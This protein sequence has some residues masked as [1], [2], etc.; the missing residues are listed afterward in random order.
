MASKFP[1]VS[2]LSQFIRDR[3]IYQLENIPGQKDLVLDGELMKPLDR[4]VGASVL[5]AHGVAKIFKFDFTQKAL[6]GCNQR[7]YI[8][9]PR[10]EMM[11]HIARQINCERSLE[12]K[13]TYRILMTPRKVSIY[14]EGVYGYVTVEEFILDLIPLD[15]DVL[16]LELSDFLPRFY[17]HNDYTWLNTVA[18]SLVHFQSVYRQIP[19]VCGIGRAAKKIHE[20]MLAMTEYH[21]KTEDENFEIGK[22]FIIDRDVDFVT[23]LSSQLTYEGILDETFGIQSGYIEFTKEITGKDKPTR[24]LLSSQDEIYDQIRN[25]HFSTVFEFLSWKVKEVQSGY[26][27]RHSLTTVGAMKNFVSNELKDLSHRHKTLAYHIGACEVV[28]ARKTKSFENFEEIMQTE[29]SLLEGSDTKENINFIE[30]CINR[31]FNCEQTLRLLCL[32]SLTNDGINS[33]HYKQLSIQFIHTYG[34]D[35]LPTLHNLRKLH[36]FMEQEQ[37]LSKPLGKMAAGVAAMAKR[38]SYQA[39]V[40]KLNLVPK[41]AED[42]SLK[43]PRDMSYVFSGAYTPTSCRLVEEVL[44]RNGFTGLEDVTKLLPGETFCSIRSPIPKGKSRGSSDYPAARVVMVFFLG[45]CTFAEIAA[46]RLL[47]RE[48]GYQFL[49]ATTCITNG[50]R[51]IQSFMDN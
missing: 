39:L 46:L 47:G 5:K 19:F 23:P 7:L 38:S 3:L 20:M 37:S 17:L 24:V 2:L 34:F 26:D 6:P 33:K 30:E 14:R 22:L 4:I 9:R 50:S 40:K 29:H 36:L 44:S 41:S 21:Q 28:M 16:S 12:Q 31:K 18:K 49:I 1:D 10:I 43:S 8:V 51:M 11:E 48:K 27:K 35:M 25:K 42:I 32:L 13:R 15:R 45:G